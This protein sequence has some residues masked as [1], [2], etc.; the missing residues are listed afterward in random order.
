[1]IICKVVDKVCVSGSSDSVVWG[2][3]PTDE[4]FIWKGGNSWERVR[5]T[6]D[7]LKAVSCGEGGV[8][9]VGKDDQVWYR[10]GTY[11]TEKG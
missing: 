1:M 9:G 8:W 6:P 11:G 2:V 3:S 7:H 5:G 4:V 10:T